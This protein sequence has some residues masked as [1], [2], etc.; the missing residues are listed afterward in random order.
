MPV[1]TPDHWTETLD[2][3]RSNID[4][5]SY[6]N[7]LAPT[8]FVGFEDNTLYISV[9]SEFYRSWLISNYEDTILNL[10]DE[11]GFGDCRL[12]FEVADDPESQGSNHR[13]NGSHHASLVPANRQVSF[14]QGVGLKDHYTFENFVVGE[15]NRF[16]HAVGLSVADPRSHAYNPLFIYGGVGLGKTHLMQAVGHKYR[17]NSPDSRVVY[18][19]A[20]QF[21]I[22]FID[23]ITNARQGQFRSHFRNVDL[24]LIDDVQFLLGKERTQTEFFHTFNALYDTGKKIVISSDRPPKELDRLEERL[25]SRFEWGLIVDVQAPDLETRIAILRK[26]AEMSGIS[27]TNDVALYIAENVAGNVRE[28][29]GVLLRLKA[30]ALFHQQGIS[31]DM[32]ERVLGHLLTNKENKEQAGVVEIQQIVCSHFG[33]SMND[34]TGASRK[35]NLAE[36]RHICMYLCKTLT[37][38]SF[39]E[40]AVRF[41][42]RDHTSVMHAVRKVERLMDSDSNFKNLVLFLT[43][44][45]NDRSLSQ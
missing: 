42:G 5:E 43:R 6:F 20:E 12:H 15:N 26:K 39:P 34:L 41:G 35:K 9:P 28:L 29:E 23:A 2:A 21:M 1:F 27:L 10:L 30:Y 18:V 40:I 22:S 3:L 19:S 25:R 24:L 8:R 7:W 14:P 38:H 37:D 16:A 33:V 4:D 36:P 13:G 11:R 17:A 32:A 31:R 44:K 45:V